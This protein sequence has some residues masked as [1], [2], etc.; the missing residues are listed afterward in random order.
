[1]DGQKVVR[2]AGMAV[3]GR[4]DRTVTPGMRSLT[5]HAEGLTATPGCVS[6]MSMC[7]SCRTAGFRGVEIAPLSSVVD[8]L[9]ELRDGT[10]RAYR[11]ALGVD[12]T[13]LPAEFGE[14]SSMR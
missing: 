13:E 7:R 2:Y 4:L 14:V 10:Y 5:V 9:V 11:T 12:G 3:G 6:T 8:D 1:V